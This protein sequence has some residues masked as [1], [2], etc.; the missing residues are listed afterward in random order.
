MGEI[1]REVEGVDCLRCTSRGMQYTLLLTLHDRR[2]KVAKPA[3]RYG[4]D[5]VRNSIPAHAQ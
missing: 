1:V 4:A 3:C 5:G 2:W